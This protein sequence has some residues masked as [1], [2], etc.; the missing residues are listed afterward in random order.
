M[1]RLSD[2]TETQIQRARE[3]VA[4]D[5]RKMARA[6][7]ET[8]DYAPHVTEAEKDAR[9]RKDKSF[10]ADIEAGLVDHNFTVAQRIWF[11]LTGE[12]VALL[13]R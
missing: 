5:W 11:E 10:A 4:A 13:P 8:D 9:F 12:C 1:K 3:K 7:R 2:F 6:I